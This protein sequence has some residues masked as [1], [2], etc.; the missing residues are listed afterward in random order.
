MG[1]WQHLTGIEG[2]LPATITSEVPMNYTYTLDIAD[3]THIQNKAQLTV[4]ALLLNKETG[5]VLNT[6]KFKF[7]P[8]PEPSVVTVTNCSRI[9]GDANPVFEYTVAGGALEGTP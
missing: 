5:K 2:S 7:T 6:A 8:D 1:V 9:Y 3:N 4:V